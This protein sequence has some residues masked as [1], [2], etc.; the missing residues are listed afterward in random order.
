ML[1][2][3]VLGRPNCNCL[4]ERLT[5]D[6][7]LYIGFLAKIKHSIWSMVFIGVPDLRWKRPG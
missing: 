3:T 4:P 1:S 6:S 2:L 5:E 7:Q